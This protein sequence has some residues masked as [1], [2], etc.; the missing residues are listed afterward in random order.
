[1][2]TIDDMLDQLGGKRAF[3]TLDAQTVTRRFVWVHLLRR[4]LCLLRTR[5]GLYKFRVMPFG[6]CNGPTM[7]QRLMQQ[8]LRGLGECWCLY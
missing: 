8:T 4:K 3:S 1:M 7:F 2:P 6:V 5:D